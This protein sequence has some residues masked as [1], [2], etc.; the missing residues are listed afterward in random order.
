MNFQSLTSDNVFELISDG[1][2][3]IGTHV[4]SEHFSGMVTSLEYER[5]QDVLIRLA[6][7]HA[8]PGHDWTVAKKKQ[9][10]RCQFLLSFSDCYSVPSFLI[11]TDFPDDL[12]ITVPQTLAYKLSQFNKLHWIANA[13]VKR[14]KSISTLFNHVISELGELTNEFLAE[15][16]LTGKRHNS[17]VEEEAIDVA[18]AA[19][20][21]YFAVM[22]KNDVDRRTAITKLEKIIADKSNKWLDSLGSDACML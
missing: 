18:V 13:E 3:T 22:A 10:R 16:A 4:H 5:D 15:S 1:L 20:G 9:S 19:I 11:R 7:S 14:G 2:L 17:S 6:V 8:T 12:S 21:L